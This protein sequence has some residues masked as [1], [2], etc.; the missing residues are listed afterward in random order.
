MRKNLLL[1]ISLFSTGIAQAQDNKS[2]L[3]INEVMQSNVE[4]I[5]DD[6]HEFPDSWVELYN[7]TD[8]TIN[9]KDYSLWD[10]DKPN[11]AWQLPDQTVAAHQWVLVYCDKEDDKGGMHA[12]FRLDSGKAKVYLFKN[13]ERVDSI[14]DL[15][16]Q[17]S[18]DIAYGRKTDGSNEWG[19]QLTP[20]PGKANSGEIC[21]YD[22]ILGKPVFSELG[23]VTS[24]EKAINLTLNLIKN[25]LIVGK[26]KLIV[27]F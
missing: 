25:L 15:K 26:C 13:G 11:K 23:R 19:Y 3:V 8:Q 27:C 17:K 1:L 22:H 5:M 14:V 16:K 21:D 7:T 24:D 9:L 6:I 2:D 20:T 10:K 12:S 4:C 18:P